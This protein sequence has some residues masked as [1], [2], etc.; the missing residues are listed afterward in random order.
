MR[1]VKEYGGKSI[2]VY[3]PEN[4]RSKQIAQRLIQEGRA[5]FKSEANYEKGAR[6]EDLVQ[7]ILDAMASDEILLNAMENQQ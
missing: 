5:N 2:A 4:E 7:K 6:M 3:N 1:L